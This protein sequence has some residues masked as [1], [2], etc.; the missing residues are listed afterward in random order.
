MND[1][2]V[3]AIA[4]LGEKT[5]YICQGDNLLWHI[6]KDLQHLKELTMGYPIVMGRKTFDS[7]GKPLPGRFNIVLTRN[8]DIETENSNYL[9]IVHNIQ[10]A[11]E[12]AEKWCKERSK[13]KY[14]IFGGAQIYDLALDFTDEL[15]L[16]LV[17]DEKI[18]DGQFP[19]YEDDFSEID[20][21]NSE[22]QYDEKENVKFRW[23]HFVKIKNSVSKNKLLVNIA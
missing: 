9:A 11:R 3:I 13:D 7:I 19:T 23:A 22:W 14:F 1:I 18:G 10:E 4:A 8:T 16:T 21:E 17:K 6:S 20:S 12:E 2:K 5:R 15:Y